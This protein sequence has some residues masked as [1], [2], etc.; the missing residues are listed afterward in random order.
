VENFLTPI[1]RHEEF[2]LRPSELRALLEAV[3]AQ[4]ARRMQ[5][6]TDAIQSARKALR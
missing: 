5:T 1:C 6:V 3:N 4:M 2:F